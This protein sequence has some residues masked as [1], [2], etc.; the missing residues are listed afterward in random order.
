MNMKE[1]MNM[2]KLSILLASSLIGIAG[3]MTSCSEDYSGPDPVDVTANYSNKYLSKSN[4]TL[5]YDGDEV[6]GKSVDFSTVKGE[7]GTLTLYDILPGEK[8]MKVSNIHLVGDADG[9][10][11]KGHETANDTQSTFNY[12]GRVTKGQLTLNLTNVTMANANIWAQSYKLSDV[13]RGTKKILDQ[14]YDSE[15]GDWVYIWK[16]EENQLI[17]SGCYLHT[18]LEPS[19]TGY[20]TQMFTGMIQNV[21]GFILPQVL[22]NVTLHTNGNITA[23]YSN[24]AIS[25][26]DP[27]DIMGIIGL[28]FGELTD[29]VI[30]PNLVNRTYISSPKGLANWYQKDG[31]LMLKLN[32]AN[33]ITQIAS[34]NNRIDTNILNA[35]IDA[36]SQMDAIKLK[37]LLVT[38][39]KNLNNEIL[40]ILVNI[41]DDSFKEIFKWLINGI[42]MCITTENGY[43]HIYL[44]QT[45]L[46]PLFNVLPD[47][48]PVVINI[49]PDSMKESLG[50]T[51]SQLL[52]LLP[53]LC[54]SAKAFDLGLGVIPNE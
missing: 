1:K 49:L 34:N 50:D 44:D 29:D 24:D 22:Q 39:N 47:I 7:I 46:I 3:L 52:T 25:G 13:K 16:E 23:S 42:P 33:I 37:G 32:L 19:E 6:T 30:A 2:K 51:V 36:I 48:A 17:E 45:A 43:T 26:F 11:F 8:A 12:E 21:L 31:L 5:T 4:L 15:K 40:G 10:S 28:L 38:L 27:N 14:D 41:N 18:E 20:S 53:T 54:S 35:I 9:Y